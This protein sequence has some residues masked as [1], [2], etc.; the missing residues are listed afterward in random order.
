MAAPLRFIRKK[1]LSRSSSP[2]F[3]NLPNTNLSLDSLTYTASIGCL[4]T[5]LTKAHVS[6]IAPDPHQVVASGFK[7]LSH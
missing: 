3:S 5:E 7:I 6:V 4:T 1:S 2:Y